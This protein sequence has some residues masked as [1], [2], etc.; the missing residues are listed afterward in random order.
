VDGSVEVIKEFEA[1]VDCWISEA[2]TGIY[3]AMNKGIK[4]ARGEYLLFL[5]SG[6]W[7]YNDA[8]IVIQLE[9]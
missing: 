6:D 7:L 4:M 8:V 5:N 9:Q 3:N 2:D 1:G